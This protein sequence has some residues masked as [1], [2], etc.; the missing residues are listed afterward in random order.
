MTDEVLRLEDFGQW[1][2]VEA[3]TSRTLTAR[4][5]SAGAPWT[6]LLLALDRAANHRQIRSDSVSALD[7][8]DAIVACCWRFGSY[9]HVLCNGETYPTFS[10]QSRSRIN[11]DEMK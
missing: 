3:D 4:L 5:R 1:E 2:A 9:A 7:E 11:Q 8:A 10:K 6:K